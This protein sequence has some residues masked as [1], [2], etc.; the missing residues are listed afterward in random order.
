MITEISPFR[1]AISGGCRTQGGVHLPD[2]D[3]A[4]LG[5]REAALSRSD[6]TSRVPGIQRACRLEGQRLAGVRVNGRTVVL[7]RVPDTGSG[8]HAL[9]QVGIDDAGVTL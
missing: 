3:L 5:G 6:Q 9:R 7:L 4:G 8:G 2:Q 1:L